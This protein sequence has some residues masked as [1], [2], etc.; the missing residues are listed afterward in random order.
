MRSLIAQTILADATLTG[1]GVVEE[2]L[3]AGDVDTPPNVLW[4]NL[5]WGQVPAVPSVAAMA[6]RNLTIWVHDE[7]N[8]YSKIDQVVRRLREL[9]PGIEAAEHDSGWI[10]SIRWA[11]DSDDLTDDGHGTIT[12]TTSYTIVGTGM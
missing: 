4:L 11:G 2:T 10:N 5:R 12:R 3:F 6:T 8:D 7:P 1:L 9:L